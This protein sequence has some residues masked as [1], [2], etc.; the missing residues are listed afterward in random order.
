MARKSLEQRFWEKTQRNGECLLWTAKRDTHGYGVFR[1]G[2]KF[3]LAH[4]VAYQ[5]AFGEYDESLCVFHRGCEQQSCVNPEHLALGTYD[6]VIA[7]R[8]QRGHHP[9]GDR[10]GM[11]LHPDRV[12]KGARHKSRT[13]PESVPSGEQHYASKLTIEQVEEIRR[14][15]ASN[16]MTYQ[17]IAERYGVHWNT[18]RDIVQ[19][20]HWRLLDR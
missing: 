7:L 11:R 17:A 9:A 6:E 12:A 20:K 13:H 10:N 18:I 14:T 2:D 4:R 3:L 8:G 19:G 5:L 16:R 15:Y 1:L